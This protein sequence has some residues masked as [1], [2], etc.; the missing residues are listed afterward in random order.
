VRALID[1]DIVC[2][3]AAVVQQTQFNWDRDTTTVALSGSPQEAAETA[4]Q[5]VRAWTKLAGCRQA[6]VCFTGTDNFRRRLLP[7]YKA[8]RTSGKPLVYQETVMAVE[9]RF[10]TERVNGLEADDL[11]GIMATSDRH[12]DNAVVVSID[13]DMRSFPGVHLNPMKETKPVIQTLTEADY[14]WLL[15]TLMGDAIDGYVGIPGVGA[16]K[17]AG[18]LEGTRSVDVMWPKVVKAFQAKKLTES[19]ALVQARVARILRHEDYD[20]AAKEI[21]LWHPTERVRI[22]LVEGQA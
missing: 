5:L 12:R 16:V 10:R 2:Y 18:I 14:W 20:R 11:L 19:A 17:A 1:G 22:P 3:R 21:L 15:Q 8:N 13:K 7:S 4:V 9:E 6:T